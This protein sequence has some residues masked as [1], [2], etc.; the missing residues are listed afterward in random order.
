MPDIIRSIEIAAPVAEVWKW[1]SSQE[2]LRRWWDRPDLEIDLVVGGSYTMTGP[3][4]GERIS[5]SVLEL[6]QERRLILSW[7]E[8]DAG[9]LHPARLGFTLEPTD[10]G[11]RV[12]IFH[13]GFAGIGKQDWPRVRDAYDKGADAH[14]L[15]PRLAALVTDGVG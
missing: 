2:A 5:G 8:H 14:A 9:W 15:L 11:V 10:A 3:D 12:T 1:F 13:D 4:G 7:F 6:D